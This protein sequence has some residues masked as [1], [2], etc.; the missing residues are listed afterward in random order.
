M[1]F[2]GGLVAR[3]VLILLVGGL[4]GGCTIN[5]MIVSDAVLT[6]DIDYFWLG[7]KRGDERTEYYTEEEK[8]IL[9]VRFKPNMAG[10][11]RT[12]RVLWYQP[13]EKVYR[14]QSAHTQRG[15]NT[16][17]IV[18]LDVKGH[19]PEELPGQWRVDLY[20]RN[21]LLVSKEFT[22]TEGA[23]PEGAPPEA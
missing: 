9:S 10:Y 14:L 2:N 3:G 7:T 11:T 16:E 13:G 5:T 15:S 20:L 6:D 21:E 8:V 18:W 17:F 22:L 12:F 4:L 1:K 23:P 19:E